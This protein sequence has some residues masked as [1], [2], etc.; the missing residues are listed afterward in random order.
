M[1]K[2][3]DEKLIALREHHAL[4]P[5]PEAVTAEI[6]TAGDSFFDPRDLVQV[7]YEMLRQVHQE[8]R[9]VTQAA[10]AFGFSRPAFYQAQ[11]ALQKKGLPGL[12]PERPGPRRAHK[13]TPEVM[14]FLEQTLAADASLGATKLT[15]LVK[16]RF[17]LLVHP[18]TIERGLARR[19]KKTKP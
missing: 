15:R 17:G 14:D 5:R 3:I 9:S 13:L 12:L 7:K 2:P 8:G 4:N 6:F 19:Q 18:R 16:E 11:K 10:V 1:A